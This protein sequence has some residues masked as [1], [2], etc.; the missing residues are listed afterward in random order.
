[1]KI[2]RTRNPSRTPG[3]FLILIFALVGSAPPALAQPHGSREWLKA[4]LSSFEQVPTVLASGHGDFTAVIN[5]DQSIAYRLSYAD[6]SSGVTGAHLHF[7]AS[8]TNGGVIA[9]LCG[10][11]A[12]PC[13]RSGT[14][15]GTLRPGDVSPLPAG[16]H[17]SVIPQGI[18][19][20]DWT[21]LVNALRSGDA[22]VN[23]HTQIFPSGEIRG[24]VHLR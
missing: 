13:P 2:W 8:H 5:P 7:G 12:R 23:V 21:A 9:F 4:E 1:M 19:T 14:L 18:A 22:Y 20:G 16:H 6:M 3:G 24:Q 10:A 11:S 15:A 17:D